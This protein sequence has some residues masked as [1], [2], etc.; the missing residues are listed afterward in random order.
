MRDIILNC[1]IL[2]DRYLNRFTIGTTINGQCHHTSFFAK[3]RQTCGT[4]WGNKHDISHEMPT[5]YCIH[6]FL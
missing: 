1:G 2:T 3:T 4:K 6:A 5:I